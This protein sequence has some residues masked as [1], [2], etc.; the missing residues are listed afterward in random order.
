MQK[1][2][3]LYCLQ[4]TKRAAFSVIVFMLY[5]LIRVERSQLLSFH[6]AFLPRQKGTADDRSKFF[7]IRA[8]FCLLTQTFSLTGK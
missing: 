5:K 6:Y 3:V 2:W 8:P 1:V 7:R 4:R